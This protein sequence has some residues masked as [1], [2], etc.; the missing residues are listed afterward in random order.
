MYIYVYIYIYIYIYIIIYIYIY[1]YTHDF[2]RTRSGRVCSGRVLLPPEAVASR[3]AACHGKVYRPPKLVSA[4]LVNSSH[5][6]IHVCARAK[7]EIVSLC[8]PN[9]SELPFSNL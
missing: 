5:E 8:L 1:I 3:S 4:S 2:G 7:D 6:F 9:G